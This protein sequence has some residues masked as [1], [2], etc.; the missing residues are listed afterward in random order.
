VTSIAPLESAARVEAERHPRAGAPLS[1]TQRII[2]AVER[3]SPPSA[4]FHTELVLRLRGN[5][6]VGT[7]ERAIN[8]VVARHDALRTSFEEATDAE[9]DIAFLGHVQRAAASLVVRLDA[10]LAV[11]GALAVPEDDW[12]RG[13]IEEPIAIDSAPLFHAH[14]ASTGPGEWLFVLVVHHLLW[15]GLSAEIFLSECADAY[16]AVRSRRP[17]EPRGEAGSYHA[18]ATRLHERLAGDAL[19]PQLR[20]WKERFEG[21][22]TECAPRGDRPYPPRPD[23]SAGTVTLGIPADDVA[24]LRRAAAGAG[25]TLFMI[26]SAA[27]AV[28]LRKHCGADVVWG[29]S[30]ANREE[31]VQGTI[32]DFG[33]G[34][35]LRVTL[36]DGMVVDDVVG[37]VMEATLGAL[38][39]QDVPFQTLVAAIQGRPQLQRHPLYQV[40]FAFEDTHSRRHF[41]LDD[42]EGRTVAGHAASCN[43]NLHFDIWRATEPA[44]EGDRGI[45]GLVCYRKDLYDE[46]TVVALVRDF[47]RIV[48]AVATQPGETVAGI[49]R[50]AERA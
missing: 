33:T 22:P 38:E 5:L 21:A 4:T 39:H 45:G 48:R 3:T 10:R 20:W 9:R 8:M 27:F 46:A 31:D 28:F 26:L 17:W 29:C 11:P 50:A 6:D 36:D 35:P 19:A 25:A 41:A 13:L 2:F 14:I 43:A 18:Y 15:D 30:F 7:L 1:P 12:V 37:H 49:L 16:A 40:I 42:L 34:L 44:H 32:G 24:S 47:Q 23:F